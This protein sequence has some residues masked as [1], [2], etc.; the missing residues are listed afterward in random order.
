ALWEK[1]DGTEGK[2]C[3][4]CHHD[5]RETM[6]GIAARYP[7]HD[8]KHGGLVNLELRINEMRVEH[9]GAEP[10]PYESDDLVALTAFVAHQ[11]RGMP[12]NVSIDGPARIHFEAGRDYYFRRRGQ[13]DLSCA[14]C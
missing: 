3:A 7:V 10:F 13:L 6:K 14:Q 8:D 4:T 12:M 11:S 1:V 5:A 2:S 9:M